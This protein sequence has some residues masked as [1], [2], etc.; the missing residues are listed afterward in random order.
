MRNFKRVLTVIMVTFF[1]FA[2]AGNCWAAPEKIN[3]NTASVQQLEKLQGVGP[4]IAQRI[5]EY[6]DNLSDGFTS[7]D[8]L[9]EVKGIGPKTLAV[10]ENMVTVSD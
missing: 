3:I 6:R 2:M 5:I 8:Q 10:I 9:T 4:T 7:V 1:V